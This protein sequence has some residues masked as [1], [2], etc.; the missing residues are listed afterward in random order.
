[1]TRETFLLPSVQKCSAIL[2]DRS[3]MADISSKKLRTGKIEFL[4]RY[5]T[6]EAKIFKTFIVYS[7]K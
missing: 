2:P 6:S 7:I 3:R 1:M 5:R 4:A